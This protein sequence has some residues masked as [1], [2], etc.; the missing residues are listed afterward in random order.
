MKQH[1]IEEVT[2]I[3]KVNF[4]QAA[5]SR[6]NAKIGV[7]DGK[8]LVFLFDVSPDVLSLLPKSPRDKLD[9]IAQYILDEHMRELVEEEYDIPLVSLF[10]EANDLSHEGWDVQYSY[11][12][13]ANPPK[14][15]MLLVPPL[16]EVEPYEIVSKHLTKVR[17]EGPSLDITLSR[18]YRDYEND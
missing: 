8:Y 14:R 16:D 4:E 17:E 7:A 6:A 10:A 1:S 2:L 5:S 15:A 11:Q 9:P 18:Q 12:L 3:G 13:Y